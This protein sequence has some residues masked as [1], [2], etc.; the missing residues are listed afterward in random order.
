MLKLIKEDIAVAIEKDPAAR[1][2][3][4]GALDQELKK[5]LQGNVPADRRKGRHCKTQTTI[6]ENAFH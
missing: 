6:N 5:Y 4:V 1:N 3:W 2:F